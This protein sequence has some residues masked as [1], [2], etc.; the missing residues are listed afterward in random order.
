MGWAEKKK[1][2]GAGMEP[3]APS[4]AERKYGVNYSPEHYK[5]GQGFTDGRGKNYMCR[6]DG[7]L[8]RGGTSVQPDPTAKPTK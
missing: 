4:T 8:Q 3:A 5:Q 7:S 6:P 2:K 1:Y